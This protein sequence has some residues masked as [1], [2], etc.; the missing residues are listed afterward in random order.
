MIRKGFLAT[1]LLGS[2][3]IGGC[4]KYLGDKTDLDFIEVPDYDATR[5]IA[6]VPI[7][8]VLDNFIQPTDVEVGFDELIYVVDKGAEEVIALDQSGREVGR[9]HIPGASA[10]AQ[11]RAFDL[12]VIGTFDTVLVNG[13][14]TSEYTFSTIYRLDQFG[15][16]GYNLSNAKIVNKVIHPFYTGRRGN[17][18]D[19]EDVVRFNKIAVLA[20]NSDP[21]LNNQYYV[22]RSGPGQSGGGL[23]PNDA[24]LYFRNNDE[25]IST[26][27]V[28]TTSGVFS[29]YFETP[30]GITTFAQPPQLSTTGGRQFIYTSMDPS[31][32]LQVQYIDFF[33]SE[34]SSFY[35]PRL[36][37]AGDT[38]Q[39]DGFI[40][41]PDKFQIP[42]DVTVAGD[43]TGYIFAVD[44]G[45]DSLY[46]F[47]GTGFEGV[48]PPAAS[49]INKYQKASFGGTGSG[50]NQF[51]DPMG[52]AY[53][54]EIVYV[55]DAGNGR[56][57]RFKLT[58]DFE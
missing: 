34:F 42:T 55:A 41:S 22:T 6:Y 1:I 8:P 52:V 11:D 32:T 21:L 23:I 35:R 16:G 15:G 56:V 39:A 25:F 47:T 27:N 5:Q 53:F 44:S 57:L 17:S 37:A 20:H 14:D 30:G 45:T 4:E 3:F 33:E 54:N 26:L 58:T 36:L 2:L 10:V 24:V 43:G 40:N 38:T 7:L 46:Q 12:L 13:G 29:D 31:N 19:E 28:S 18:N 51:R 9:K 50:V 48:L 49:G